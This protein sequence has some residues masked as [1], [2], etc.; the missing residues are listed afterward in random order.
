MVKTII[1]N[2][3]EKQEEFKGAC[4]TACKTSATVSNLTFEVQE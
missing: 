4:Q 3:I 1:L 2:D